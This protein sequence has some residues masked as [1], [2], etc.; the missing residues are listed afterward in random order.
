MGHSKFYGFS[1]TLV[2]DLQSPTACGD[3]NGISRSCGC[4]IVRLL[5]IVLKIV[6]GLI[7]LFNMNVDPTYVRLKETAFHIHAGDV[8]LDLKSFENSSTYNDNKRLFTLMWAGHLRSTLN[9]TIQVLPGAP[10]VRS[11]DLQVVDCP[12][13]YVCSELNIFPQSP[14]MNASGHDSVTFFQ[15]PF[16]RVHFALWQPPAPLPL[17]LL[18]DHCR[19]Y[20]CA[21]Y[22]T[23]ICAQTSETDRGTV[24]TIGSE[25]I[26]DILTLTT[27]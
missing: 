9:D 26:N 16:Y 1:S 5:L 3:F 17:P 7:L 27:R 20:G 24:L 19:H 18:G 6:L 11:T 4:L 10:F 12:E 23:V 8:P 21:T 2:Q 22:G 15:L 13:Y 25:P 14:R